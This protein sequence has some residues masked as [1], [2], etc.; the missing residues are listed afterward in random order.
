MK[1]PDAQRVPMSFLR[2]H[3]RDER[4]GAKTPDRLPLLWPSTLSTTTTPRHTV[5]EIQVCR[6]HAHVKFIPAKP[7]EQDRH[8]FHQK[9]NACRKKK[10]NQR[11]N[12]RLEKMWWPCPEHAQS[13]K[14]W[15][16]CARAAGVLTRNCRSHRKLAGPITCPVDSGTDPWLKTRQKVFNKIPRHLHRATCERRE[17]C[18]LTPPAGNKWFMALGPSL[19]PTKW[20]KS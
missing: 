14:Q 6:K 10:N 20:P 4:I 13:E 12:C 1:T 18:G 9:W 7:E 16:H 8:L 2:P 5:F 15:S 3:S 17:G 11:L 19:F